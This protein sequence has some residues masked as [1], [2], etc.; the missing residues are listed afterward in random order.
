MIK[1][2]KLPFL[3]EFFG[4]SVKQIKKSDSLV[5]NKEK[6]F[7]FYSLKF[8]LTILINVMITFFFFVTFRFTFFNIPSK[9]CFYGHVLKKFSHVTGVYLRCISHLVAVCIFSNL[10]LYNQF[11]L[12]LS[13]FFVLLQF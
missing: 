4:T 8:Y 13:H 7:K 11:N 12:I 1:L 9:M 6:L 5:F 2:N 10:F 3:F